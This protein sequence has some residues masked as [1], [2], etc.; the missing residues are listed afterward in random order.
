MLPQATIYFASPLSGASEVPTVNSTG[1]GMTLKEINGDEAYLSGSFANLISPFNGGSH[2]HANYAGMAGPVV[3]PLVASPDSAGFSGTFEVDDNE[4]EVNDSF[5]LATLARIYYVNV[6]TDSFPGGEI[7]GQQM[8]LATHYFTTTLTGI[9]EVPPNP[10]GGHG[11]LKYEIRG[12]TLT[13]HG[14]F[15]DLSS[16]YS[17]SHIHMA[18]ACQNG[19]VIFPL[20]PVVDSAGFSGVYDAEANEFN[21]DSAA[22][23]ALSTGNLYANVHTDTL[24]GG[25]IRGQVLKE[26]NSFPTDEAFLISPAPGDTIGVGGS[27]GNTFTV[28]WNPA[29][30]PDGNRLV[31]ILQV[32]L[33]SAFTD[34]LGILLDSVAMLN[35]C[36][37][38][39]FTFV[40]PNIDSLLDSLGIAVGQT[41][42]FFVRVLAS[43]GSLVT[44]GA[45]STVTAQRDSVTVSQ[46]VDLELDITANVTQYAQYVDVNYTIT[47]TNAGTEEATGV[48]VAAGLPTGMVHTANFTNKGTYNLFFERWDVGTLAPGETGTL[49]LVL[50]PLV[51][52]IHITNFVQVLTQDQ[53]DVDS[54]PGN[55]TPPTPNEDDEAAVTVL[56]PTLPPFGGVTADLSISATVDL[57]TYD[58]YVDVFY[59]VFLVNSGPDTAAGVTIRAGLPQGM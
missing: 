8:P 16:P 28:T 35:V 49:T 18:P 11:D 55:G 9:N 46:G 47:I 43:D 38:T 59:H 23:A 13:V 52:D 40:V 19:G 30:D 22:I 54:A 33:D 4:F 15:N 48:T 31:Y 24:P 53:P 36:D 12:N 14:S 10:S 25:E 57:P 42:S 37:S 6:H 56:H 3:Q 27:S 21:L 50:F 32:A 2:I 29:F 41:F 5:I 44:P 51:N 34:T 45:V 7:R 39:S 26:T 17:A 20:T 58:I 1:G